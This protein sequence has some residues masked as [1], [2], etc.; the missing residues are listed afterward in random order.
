MP[1]PVSTAATSAAAAEDAR[2]PGEGV[3]LHALAQQP[4]LDDPRFRLG[5]HVAPVA[6]LAHEVVDVH[7]AGAKALDDLEGGDA[8]ADDH[9][10]PGPAAP[11]DDVA[12]VVHAVQRDDAVKLGARHPGG[13]RPGPGGQQQAVVGELPA[14]LQGHRVCGGI[15]ADRGFR[16]G[17]DV[18]AADVVG[19]ERE[20]AF[21]GHLVG[22]VVGETRARVVAVRIGAD[23]HD[24]GVV[25]RRRGSPRPPPWSPALRR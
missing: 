13:D 25:V 19:R 12:G 6:V 14:A 8:A 1:S 23:Q 3:D 4:L 11:P 22:E 20:E 16:D 17:A 24:L 2:Q 10:C 9:R 21:F 15:D 5:Q 18:Q 7:A